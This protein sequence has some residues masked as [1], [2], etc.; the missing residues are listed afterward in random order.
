M[1]KERMS[2]GTATHPST[3][4]MMVPYFYHTVLSTTINI[5]LVPEGTA[6]SFFDDFIKAFYASSTVFTANF[7][8]LG[9]TPIH[10]SVIFKLS[11]LRKEMISQTVSQATIASVIESSNVLATQSHR[12][13]RLMV[14]TIYT[15]AC[16]VFT[17]FLLNKVSTS[18]QSVE[19][20]PDAA[21]RD[22]LSIAFS[23][24]FPHHIIT[25]PLLILGL[26]SQS[27]STQTRI[28]QYF[29]MLVEEV[30]LLSAKGVLDLL[31]SAWRTDRGLSTILTSDL[32]DTLMF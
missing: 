32:E 2:S 18:V 21:I 27:V 19:D 7:N 15:V 9:V 29:S 4:F 25:W 16:N 5:N 6:P 14:G 1:L 23:P 13:E 8:F 20:E 24:G 26:A 10:L 11:C 30:Y 3:Q 17:D 22:I 31:Q 28:E 12:Y